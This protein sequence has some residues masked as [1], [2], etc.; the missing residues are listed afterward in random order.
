[1][2]YSVIKNSVKI[3]PILIYYSVNSVN[4]KG[5]KPNI[6]G[7]TYSFICP[8][9]ALS[10]YLDAFSWHKSTYVQCTDQ[11][12]INSRLAKFWGDHLIKVIKNQTAVCN[13][14]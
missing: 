3:L 6:F 4:K 7:P 5:R 8:S 9:V 10:C 2:Y 14:V 11:C 1:M 12:S 13:F